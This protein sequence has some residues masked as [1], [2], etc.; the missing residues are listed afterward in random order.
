VPGEKG[1]LHYGMASS[2]VH[3]LE[4]ELKAAAST[5]ATERAHR[6]RLEEEIKVLLEVQSEANDSLHRAWEDLDTWHEKAK[7]VTR[8]S[9]PFPALRAAI[10][11]PCLYMHS[12]VTRIAGRENRGFGAPI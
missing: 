4:D 9:L 8:I 11:L 10:R 12:Q 7:Q 6:E 2:E 1:A 3:R 5:L